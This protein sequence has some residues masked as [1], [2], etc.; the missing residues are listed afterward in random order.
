MRVVN[1]PPTV[2]RRENASCRTGIAASLVIA[3]ADALYGSVV[4][5][6]GHGPAAATAHIDVALAIARAVIIATRLTDAHT[7]ARNIDADLGKRRGRGKRGHRR[8]TGKQKDPFPHGASPLGSLSAHNAFVR[9]LFRT[10]PFYW[11]RT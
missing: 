4:T 8:S 2:L 10:I 1:H 6:D 9:R 7:D 5:L 3:A 11:L